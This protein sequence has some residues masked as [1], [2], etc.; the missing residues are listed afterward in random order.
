[1]IPIDCTNAENK[2]E[3]TFKMSQL[4]H[5]IVSEELKNVNTLKSELKKTA[6][7]WCI[8]T[9]SHGFSNVVKADSWTI[10]IGWILVIIA[11]TGYCFYSE[12]I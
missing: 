11:F 7:E 2:F 6:K 8:D 3:S 4:K 5:R 9:T 1:M 12:K 10:R